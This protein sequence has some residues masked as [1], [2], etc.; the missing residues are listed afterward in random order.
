MKMITMK[1]DGLVS[2]TIAADQKS[3]VLKAVAVKKNFARSLNFK[4][5]TQLALKLAQNE[6]IHEFY[7]LKSTL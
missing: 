5:P 1:A 4:N 3:N 2:F 6:P 7:Y